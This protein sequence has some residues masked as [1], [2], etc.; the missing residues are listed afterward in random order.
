[1]FERIQDHKLIITIVKKNKASQVVHASRLAGARGG[2]IIPATG[3]KLKEKKRIFGIPVERERE[4]IF[5][6]VSEE[7]YFDV[8]TAIESTAQLDH[9]TPG[10]AIVIDIKKVMGIVHLTGAEIADCSR[11]GE[12]DPM[13][14]P[15]MV[16]HDLII[17]IVNNGDSEEVVDATK[18][19]G[20]DGGTVIHGRGTGIHEKAKLFNI[21]IEPEKEVILTLIEREKTP[22]VLKEINQA[23]GLDQPGKG[24]AFVLEVERTIGINHLINDQLSG[25]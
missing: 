7:I 10:I 3:L 16:N 24:I 12:I 9:K 22:G 20:A 21:M 18:R 4:V 15:K 11:K 1:M 8:L 19:A 25:K 17:T 13:T 6:I 5:T 23:V 2:T 14:D